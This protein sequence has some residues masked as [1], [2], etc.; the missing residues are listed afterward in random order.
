MA[1]KKKKIDSY[2]ERIIVLQRYASGETPQEIAEN[3]GYELDDVIAAVASAKVDSQYVEKIV[4][5]FITELM[6]EYAVADDKI[7]IIFATANI[8]QKCKDYL[9]KSKEGS[10]DAVKEE[11]ISLDDMRKIIEDVVD[12]GSN[13]N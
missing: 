11:E 7:K 5:V 4:Y 12:G 8:L 1:K 13:Q 9:I 6:N 2:K 10:E 3:G